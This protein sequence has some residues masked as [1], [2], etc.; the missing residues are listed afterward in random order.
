VQIIIYTDLWDF[1][2]G[3]KKPNMLTETFFDFL[4]Q[5]RSVHPE[6][7]K[8][9]PLKYTFNG[10]LMMSQEKTPRVTSSMGAFHQER[11]LKF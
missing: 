6:K 2:L 5:L 8:K 7:Y 11:P 1:K 4:R 10:P 3:D 9:T